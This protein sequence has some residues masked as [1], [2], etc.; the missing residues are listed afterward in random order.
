MPEQQ[1]EPKWYIAHQVAYLEFGEIGR[2][3]RVVVWEDLVLIRAGSA[4]EAY[5][6]A[7]ARPAESTWKDERGREVQLHYMGLRDLRLVPGDLRDRAVLEFTDL[8]YSDNE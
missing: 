3:D 2:E 7:T 5:L 6:K 8:Q 1:G 4:A